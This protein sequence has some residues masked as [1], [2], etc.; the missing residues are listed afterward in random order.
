ME[1]KLAI[2][3]GDGIGTE[4]IAAAMTVLN[5][6]AKKFG[7]TIHGTYADIGWAAL[8]KGHKTALPDETRALCAKSDAIFFGAVGLPDRD[9]TL[10]LQQ[11]PERVALLE[12]RKGLFANLRHVVLPKNLGHLCPL[13]PALI[14]KGIDIMIIRELTGGLYYGQPQGV[15]GTAPNRQAVD[16]MAYSEMECR[17]ILKVGFETAK[18]RRK[19]LLSVDKA[20]I[21]ATSGLWREIAIDMHKQY[22]DI[23]LEHMYVDNASMQLLRRPSEFDVIVTEN[24]FG[25]ILS[26]EASMLAGSIGL[27]PSACLGNEFLA[28]YD[29]A[30]KSLPRATP[31]YEPIHGSAP[32]IAGK[33]L[34]NPI[35]TIL[36]GSMMLR[37]TFNLQKEA[38]AIDNT[39]FALLNE[40]KT[41]TGDLGGK[42]K[43]SEVAAAVIAKIQ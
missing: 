13:K 27:V 5:H 32:D 24:T 10:P 3:P 12:L 28:N 34:A 17:R 4:V 23:Q 1:M 18:K 26:D 16:T 19:K 9:K 42:A 37:Y 29:P 39:C 33:D 20:N 2:L 38:D 30:A 36:T 35:G 14:E 41:L 11:R 31:F 6:V 40:G 22:P 15:T 7:H 21:L 43:C 25:D 8:D